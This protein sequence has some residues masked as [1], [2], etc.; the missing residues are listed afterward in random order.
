MSVLHSKRLV[1]LLGRPSNL[2]SDSIN[3]FIDKK[4][5][6][7]VWHIL[8]LWKDLFVAA[9]DEMLLEGNGD[10][11]ENIIVLLLDRDQFNLSVILRDLIVG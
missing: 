8:F 10:S 11:D 2:E 5:V 6:G 1:S 4:L 9:F 3:E 7:F